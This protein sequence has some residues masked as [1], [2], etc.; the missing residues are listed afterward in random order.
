MTFALRDTHFRG[1]RPCRQP[2]TRHPCPVRSGSSSSC[3]AT[4]APRSPSVPEATRSLVPSFPDGPI[5]G[6]MVSVDFWVWLLPLRK[7]HLRVRMLHRS[8]VGCFRC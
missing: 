1:V 4:E 8:A 7:M 3:L 5:N 6:I 2:S